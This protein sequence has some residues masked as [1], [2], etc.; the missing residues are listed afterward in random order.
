M[1]TEHIHYLQFFN[2]FLLYFPTYY[3]EI[4]SNTPPPPPYKWGKKWET[5]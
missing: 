1:D 3:L 4:Y 2:F 5:Q